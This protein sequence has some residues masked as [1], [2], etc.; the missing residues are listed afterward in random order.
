MA[1]H[2]AKSRRQSKSS[3]GAAGAGVD[4]DTTLTWDIEP[5]PKLLV[6]D[7]D[8]TLWPFDAALPRYGFPHVHS[9]DGSVQCQSAVAKP[10]R[11]ASDIVLHL[12]RLPGESAVATGWRMGVASA[13]MQRN[14][15]VSLLRHLGLLQERPAGAS[16]GEGMRRQQPAAD[17]GSGGIE[18]ALMEIYGGSKTAHLRRIAAVSGVDFVDMLLFDDL[19]RNIRAAHT[20]GVTGYQVNGLEG[21]TWVALAAG[22]AAWR[23]T[24]LSKMALAS[25]LR[26]GLAHVRAVGASAAGTTVDDTEPVLLDGEAIEDRSNMP[27]DSDLLKNQPPDSASHDDTFLTVAESSAGFCKEPGAWQRGSCSIGSTRI[28]ID[29]CE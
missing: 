3:G 18:P 14:V 17:C 1:S 13:N 23:S 5:H 26:P 24:R 28:V 8:Q 4:R 11:E 29:L 15:C 22:I 20:L 19:Q 16:S 27:S 7:L 21:L 25:W 2:V 6:F 12:A 10:F 9:G